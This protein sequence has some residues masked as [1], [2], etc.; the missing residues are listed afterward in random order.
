MI[1]PFRAEKL[2]PASYEVAIR[3]EYLYYDANGDKITGTMLPSNHPQWNNATN[4][5]TTFQLNGNSI[6]FV[7]LEPLFQLPDYIA[8]RFNLKVRHV[9][10]GLLLGAGPLI[11]PGYVG[12]LNIPLH[13][14]TAEDYDLGADEGLI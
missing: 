1:H 13:N 7:S 6:A 9:Y 8:I 4:P 2:K 12:K 14:L 3:G 5:T 11:D 10:K